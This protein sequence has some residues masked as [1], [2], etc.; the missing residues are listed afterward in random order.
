MSYMIDF[1]LPLAGISR[2]EA[3]FDRAASNIASF[4]S[5]GG[6]DTVD[7]SA[8]AVAL[9]QARNNV[10]A[11]VKVAQVED[12]MAKSMLSLIA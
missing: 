2:A 8:A 7:L 12:Q 9:I 4:G 1:S 11:N 3:S 6:G 10:A 5:D